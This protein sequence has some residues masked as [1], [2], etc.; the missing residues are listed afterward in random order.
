MVGRKCSAWEV[1]QRMGRKKKKPQRSVPSSPLYSSR[2]PPIPQVREYCCQKRLKVCP[3]V[4]NALRG[5][6][7]RR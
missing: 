4:I 7:H 5:R 2:S 3:Y 6:C 1:S